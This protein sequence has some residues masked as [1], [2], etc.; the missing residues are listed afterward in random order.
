MRDVPDEVEDLRLNGDVERR[1]GLVGNDEL[2]VVGQGD[3]DDD[4]LAHSARKLEADTGRMRVLGRGDAHQ[5]HE[6]QGALPAPAAL[7]W[8]FVWLRMGSHELLA[9]FHGG[10]QK[11][12]GVLK[13]HSHAVLPHR[14]FIT[15]AVGLFRRGSWRGLMFGAVKE[16]AVASGCGRCPPS[17][18]M[19][20][21]IVTDLPLPDSPTM[22]KISPFL[23]VKGD[24]AHGVD[25]CPGR[26]QN[27]PRDS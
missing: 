13:N 27:R 22:P 21:Y 25:R 15:R 1:G 3:G 24:V 8:S 16:H 2:G 9:D 10:V 5:A 19:M 6:L 14:R 11:G 18:P 20:E 23:S 12:H 4:S 17:R 7:S 26:S